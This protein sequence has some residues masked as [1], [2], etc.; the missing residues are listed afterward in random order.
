VS[1]QDGASYVPEIGRPLQTGAIASPG[2]FPNGTGGAGIVMA[3][4]LG[5]ASTQLAAAA[6][7][8]WAEK[9]EAKKREAEERAFM[10]EG[11]CEKYPDSSACHVD[12][13]GE[14]N[15]EVNCLTIIGGEEQ[16]TL[17]VGFES[18]SGNASE[19]KYF[20]HEVTVS[21]FIAGELGNAIFWTN[22]L[23]P[24]SAGFFHVPS[25]LIQAVSAAAD[26]KLVG[27]L[28][29]LSANLLT[30]G[31]LASG[32]VTIHAYGDLKGYF[33]IDVDFPVDVGVDGG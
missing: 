21:K 1:T 27:G 9:E 15:C 28:D 14:G 12:G 11:F 22:H 13:P 23:G 8:Q 3:P 32:P 25:W 4:Y 19:A 7:Q 20:D 10:E 6:A 29:Q 16:E 18:G 5:A 2:S 24:V 26:A 17:G 31:S 30:A 33:W